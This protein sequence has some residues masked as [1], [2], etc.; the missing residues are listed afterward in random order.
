M[1][2]P[3]KLIEPLKKIAAPVFK[4]I[5][6]V[7]CWQ[8]TMNFFS[9]SPGGYIR[10]AKTAVFLTEFFLPEKNCPFLR[11]FSRFPRIFPVFCVVTPPPPSVEKNLVAALGESQPWIFTLISNNFWSSLIQILILTKLRMQPPNVQHL[12][13]FPTTSSKDQPTWSS[14]AK[15]KKRNGCTT[16]LLWVEV[17]PRLELSLNSWSRSLWKRMETSSQVSGRIHSWSTPRIPFQLLWLHSLLT[18]FKLKLW[19][20]LR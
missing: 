7:L 5:V 15:L 8:C 12:E 11:R 6:L 3:N 17:I 2:G 13:S 9:L 14:Q 4:M 19:N 18:H 10:T 16:W 20:C 1:K